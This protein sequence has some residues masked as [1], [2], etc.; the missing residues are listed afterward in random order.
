MELSAN[1]K[2]V[3]RLA[4][5]GTRT[6]P[7]GQFAVSVWRAIPLIEAATQLT[8]VVRSPDG[9]IVNELARNINFVSSPWRADILSDRSRLVA[10]GK[11]RPVLAVRL[12]DRS[13]RPVRSGVNGS[14]TI[15]EP[16]E[17]AAL[18]E[19]LQVRQ[20]SGTGS[21]TPSW[22]IEGDDGVALIELAPTMVSGP[23]HLSFGFV[24]D[25]LTR[26]QEIDSWIVP[27]DMEWTIV[28]LAEG[29]VGA[30]TVADNMEQNGKFGSDLGDHARV[31]L[32]AKGRVLGKFIM[33]LAYDSAKQADDQ[34]LLG[35]L[36]PKAYYTVFG[37]GSDRRFDAASREKLYLRIETSTFYALYGD[38]IT[39]FDQTVLARYNRTATG[40]KAEGLFGTLHVQGFAADIATRYRRDEIQGGGL[41][42]P[43]RLHDR[44]IVASSERVAIEVR[45]RLRSEIVVTRRELAKFLDY[46]IDALTGTITFKEP[47]LSRDFDLNPQFIVIDY[48]AED[49]AG[50]AS[51]N[52]GVRADYTVGDDAVRI[53][54]T[55]ITDKGDGPRTDM[56]AVDLRA[57]LG[58][59]TEIRAE[60]GL[61]RTDGVNDEAWLIEAEHRT[62][63]VDL[64][65]YARSLE[66]GYGTG[67]Q[68]GAELGRRKFGIDARY[69][70]S[71]QLSLVAS[72]WYDESLA[73]AGN[74]RAVQVNATYRAGNIEGRLGI[75]HLADKLADGANGASTVL[76]AAVSQR[77]LDNK[78]EL[79]ASTSLALSKTGSIDLPARHRLRAR[80]SVTDWLRLVGTYEIAEGN[81]IK[82]RTMNGGIE[83]SPWQGARMLTTIGEQN[84]AEQGKR[85]FA[86]FGLA[87]TLAVT[88]NLSLDATIDGNRK[89]GGAS[90][91]DVINPGHPVASGGH[92][93]QD[94][95]LFEDFAAVTLGSSW[96]KD[97]WAATARAEYRGGEFANRYGFA[98]GVIRQ[99]GD[100]VVA[101]SGISWTHADG[102]NGAQSEIVEA[103][104]SAAYRPGGSPFAALGKLE[105]RSDR[106]T[107]AV[108][109]EDTP[110][111][112]T[113]LTVTGQAKSQRLVA[114]LSTNWSPR[115]NVN[116]KLVRRTELGLFLGARYNLDRVNDFDLS[117]TTVLGGLDARIGLSERVEVG[118]SATVRKNLENGTTS[119][120]LGPQVSFAPA[121]NTL[122]T[123]GYNV[124]GFRDRDFAAARST[125]RGIYATVRLKFDADTFGFLGLRGAH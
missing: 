77:L 28:G 62:G 76:E 74:R 79:S 51:W 86:A 21:T 37:D 121:K 53:G 119:F 35:T 47:V 101:G 48:E 41:T 113:A 102:K 7:T 114:S 80:Y 120:A 75:A 94:G 20:L 44:N 45:D 108:A 117:G 104:V 38:F 2:R 36:D 96:R 70:L 66:E 122:M 57:R 93:S 123:F 5:D 10:D 85:T 73:D 65:A 95:A 26:R 14:V 82:A 1:G 87:Q 24:D 111:G 105:F 98:G 64:I 54:L 52:A 40:L 55:G 63:A 17:S 88:T 31:A 32:F 39:G 43:Y 61:S 103:T 109:G 83:L 27:G 46:D 23:L 4:F 91:F 99:L 8:A 34:R 3:D 89:L 84:V 115:S 68:T 124:S 125:D 107:G 19:Q 78:L 100:G 16:Y 72:A 112:R 49:G 33:T 56:G 29:S 110:I 25:Q 118:G 13:G 106:M 6:A 67:Q 12:T 11:T 116:G 50:D 42:G 92:L 81:K 18:L 22:I 9:A 71:P 69:A 30:K 59:T 15:N 60:L 90:V 58:A 97:Q